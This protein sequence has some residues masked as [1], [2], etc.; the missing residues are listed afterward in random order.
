MSVRLIHL[1][2]GTGVHFLMATY[3][4]NYVQLNT[5]PFIICWAT[6]IH[7][8]IVNKTVLKILVDVWV[9]ACTDPLLWTRHRDQGPRSYEYAMCST[10]ADTA[11]N[12]LT[13]D[14]TF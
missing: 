1:V 4:Y 5:V 3:Y 13:T 7:V 12:Q 10:G 8:V 6:D 2:V 9:R 14:R 11:F